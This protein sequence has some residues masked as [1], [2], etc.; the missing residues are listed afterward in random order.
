MC[1]ILLFY[2]QSLQLQTRSQSRTYFHKNF[3]P[4]S[5]KTYLGIYLGISRWSKCDRFS[6][7]IKHRAMAFTWLPRA[8]REMCWL[9]WVNVSLKARF[10][11]NAHEWARPRGSRFIPAWFII[12]VKNR[13]INRIIHIIRVQRGRD[14]WL[15]CIILYD[16]TL[17]WFVFLG[18]LKAEIF[19]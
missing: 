6:T 16:I 18:Y 15:D 9:E 3:S 12:T 19:W 14:A 1:E 8:F 11:I 17:P 4:I 2:M 5:G 7:I 10:R 13:I